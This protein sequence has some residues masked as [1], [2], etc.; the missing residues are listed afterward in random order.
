LRILLIN[1]PLQR[2]K[3]INYVYLPLG[4]GS[5][6]AVLRDAGHDVR[7]YNAEIM[8]PGEEMLHDKGYM[9]YLEQHSRY[10]AT[11][12]DAASPIWDTIDKRIREF[13]PELVGVSVM[14]AKVGS[15]VRISQR[16]KAWNP[17]VP[18]IW[19]GPH[20][21]AQLSDMQ[22]YPEVDLCA[23]GEAEDTVVELAT[24]LAEGKR[25]NDEL[26]H[27]E[28]LA[29]RGDDGQWFATGARTRVRELDRFPWPA[30]D[31]NWADPGYDALT[32]GSLITVRGCPFDCWFCD[33]PTYWGKKV[34]Y[35]TPENVLAEIRELKE[36]F[37][38]REFF[39]WDDTFT[40]RRQHVTALCEAMIREKIDIIWRCTSRVDCIN[41][42]M[43]DLM[44][45]AGCVNIDV[46]I[47]S[48]SDRTLIEMNKKETRQQLLD[49]VA[50]I[51]RH[52]INVNAYF[53]LGFPEE[54]EED[55]R[56]TLEL[57]EEIDLSRIY[58]SI[59]TPYP[60]TGLW[61]SA[62]S[63][64]LIEEHPQWHR[65]S[66]QSPDNHFSTKIPLE[67]FRELV[68][69]AARIVDRKNSR[70]GA[71]MRQ[72]MAR[73]RYFARHPMEAVRIVAGYG[74]KLFA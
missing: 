55:A 5:L 22:H 43:L 17:E 59:F 61:D 10:L 36:R 23:L 62:R 44:R 50:Q 74:K 68:E 13:D 40:V 34:R 58:L 15:S 63:H 3:G 56:A 35:R 42:E 9:A 18:V 69:E 65:Y 67:K 66:H 31:L 26:Q 12:E 49:G 39:F 38:V 32:L 71:Y 19:G 33:T 48:G 53:M 28:G 4:L 41:D 6:A 8:E 11:L 57:M 20:P 45:R 47:E 21:A 7:I 60:G 25:S 37:G 30:R 1:P 2:L 64:E 14:T 72:I 51:Q 29:L 54:T 46:G 24:A 70:P 27:I 16:V 73:R 52:G